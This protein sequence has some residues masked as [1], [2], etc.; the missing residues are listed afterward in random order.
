MHKK[1]Y[2]FFMHIRADAEKI[3]YLKNK[4]WCIENN[5]RLSLTAP[6]YQEQNAFV[7]R[8]HGMASTMSRS[9]LVRAHLPAKGKTAEL[10]SF[11][12]QTWHVFT[13]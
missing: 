10:R 6:K 13:T 9:M 11:S 5:I 2:P 12:T 4:G 7:E 1:D 3:S 8:L